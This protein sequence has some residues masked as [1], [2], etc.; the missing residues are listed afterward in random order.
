M[1]NQSIQEELAKIEAAIAAQENLR[2]TG[3]FSDAEI[4]AALTKLRQKKA[5]LTAKLP[6]AP[7]PTIVGERGVNVGGNVG[8]SIITGDKNT[9]TQVGGDFVQGD[10]VSG[11]KISVGDITDSTGVAIGPNA[12]AQVQQGVSG[13]ELAALFQAVYQKVEA[14]PADPDV[15]KEEIVAQVQQIE[16]EVTAQ[17][18]P[19]EKK[20]ERWLRNLANM[21]P[22]IVDVMAASLAGPVA[23]G[24]AIFKKIVDK[25]K[26]ESAA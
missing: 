12:Q 21:A 16:A 3:T 6:G 9:V 11:D 26:N 2:G 10:K 1:S 17:E 7:G 5:E 19:N 22:D 25:V 23:A 14:R 18:Q 4:E 13:A 15:E 24:A 8:G 20:L